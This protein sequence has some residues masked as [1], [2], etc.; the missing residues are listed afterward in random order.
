[1]P[2][3]S[4]SCPLLRV[5]RSFIAPGYSA[6]EPSCARSLTQRRLRCAV[7]VRSRAEDAPLGLVDPQVVDAR[8]S[9]AHQAM[10]VE[11]PQLVAV[12]S[13]PLALA[14]VTLVLEAHRDAAVFEAPQVLS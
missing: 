4:R 10:L 3:T 13:P 14:I 9:S 8:L 6:T 5:M 2:M 7:L 11:L 1:M 12:A